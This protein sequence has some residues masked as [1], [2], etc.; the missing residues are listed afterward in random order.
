[1]DYNENPAA[2]VEMLKK[3]KD[4]QAKSGYAWGQFLSRDGGRCLM[5]SILSALGAS[6]DSFKNPD[7]WEEWHAV[8]GPAAQL[9]GGWQASYSN[10]LAEDYQ[11]EQANI[12]LLNFLDKRIAHFEA[13]LQPA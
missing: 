6:D 12:E 4:I 5:G 2:A 10:S 8:E 7:L 1:M 3:A 9:A 13:M 11:P